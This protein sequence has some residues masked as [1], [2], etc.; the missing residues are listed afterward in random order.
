MNL[1]PRF[2][3]S[4]DRTL[5][6]KTVVGGGVAGAA[7]GGLLTTLAMT[8]GILPVT[9]P[10]PPQ[11]WPHAAMSALGLFMAADVAATCFWAM[12]ILVVAAPAWAILSSLGVRCWSAAMLLGAVLAP[13]P[14]VL[15]GATGVMGLL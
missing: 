9:T 14:F 13:A 11:E 12:G 15:I 7:T 10:S 5:N 1:I 3:H 4:C 2:A 8:A 6:Q